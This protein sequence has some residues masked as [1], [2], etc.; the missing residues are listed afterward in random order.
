MA[1][2]VD[3]ISYSAWK[4]LRERFSVLQSEAVKWM[5]MQD[6]VVVAIGSLK[7]VVSEDITYLSQLRENGEQYVCLFVFRCVYLLLFLIYVV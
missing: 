6:N 3:K 5:Q 1:V 4:Q 2:P 7:S